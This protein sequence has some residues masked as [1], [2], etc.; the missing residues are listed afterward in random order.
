MSGGGIRVKMHGL[1]ELDTFLKRLPKEL[2]RK[3]YRSVLSTG[4]R[5]IAKNAKNHVN[6][7]TG[8]LRK[9]IGIKVLSKTK[10][11][12]AIIGPKLGVTGTKDGKAIRA[13]YYAK[14]VEQGTAHSEAQP[15]MR[16]AVDESGNEVM[17]KMQH[18]MERFMARAI[19]R[20]R[21]KGKF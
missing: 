14:N 17:R 15:F 9:S 18:G 21:T 2:H 20:L 6:D 4:A 13:T 19:T 1:K 10:N 11:P 8:L 7:D 12:R 5:V 3:A 16:P